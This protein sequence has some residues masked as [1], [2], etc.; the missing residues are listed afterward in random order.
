MIARRPR[1]CAYLCKESISAEA[2]AERRLWRD[3]SAFHCNLFSLG[4]R[5]SSTKGFP[6][7]EYAALFGVTSP[8]DLRRVGQE[9]Y[10]ALRTLRQRCSPLATICLGL[11][12]RRSFEEA[13]V[14]GGG[15]ERRAGRSRIVVYAEERAILVP[16]ASWPAYH[17]VVDDV[18][19]LLRSEPWQVIL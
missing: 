11:G 8:E 5:R 2:F 13:L 12:A 6:T 9:R 17:A 18:A 3:K 14:L 19:R 4:Y 15:D 1:L 7:K 10:E 16:H